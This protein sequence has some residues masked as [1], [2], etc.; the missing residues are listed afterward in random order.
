MKIFILTLSFCLFL[1]CSTESVN[2]EPES[3]QN[4]FQYILELNTSYLLPFVSNCD[5]NWLLSS[6]IHDEEGTIIGYGD[7]FF[8]SCDEDYFTIFNEYHFFV[9]SNQN[10]SVLW[11]EPKYTYN[12]Y[13]E[14]QLP[15]FEIIQSK[16][17][18]KIVINI[19]HH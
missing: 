17:I 18:T 12:Y 11:G 6:V 14:N 15:V 7:D 13:I 9:F 8:T 10:I 2:S 4:P 5:E 1:G 19:L 3:K 16:N